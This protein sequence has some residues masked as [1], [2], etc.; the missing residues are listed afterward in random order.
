MNRLH[1]RLRILNAD[2]IGK[3]SW[4]VI[5]NRS[6]GVDLRAEQR[7]GL[8]ALAQW[9]D[10]VCVATHVTGPDDTLRDE[11]IKAFSSGALMVAMHI[12]K[13]QNEEFPVSVDPAGQWL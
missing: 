2:A 1:R 7:T 3:V 12:P 8:D 5:D 6:R 4:R 9:Q 13:A 11:E 10:K